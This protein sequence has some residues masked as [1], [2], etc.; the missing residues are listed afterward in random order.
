[1][2]SFCA[3]PSPHIDAIKD[4]PPELINNSGTPVRGMIALTPPTFNMK[5]TIKYVNTPKRI[6]LEEVYFVLNDI[7]T[8]G[9]NKKLYAAI[10]P[11]KPIT[12][13]SS[14]ITGKIKS[15]EGF[16]KFMYL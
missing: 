5:W 13:S 10:N 12:P 15:F 8:I 11:A 6:I 1:M 16:G 9:I 4:E 7:L 3:K 2:I 14:T